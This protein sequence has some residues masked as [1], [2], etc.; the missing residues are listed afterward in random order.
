VTLFPENEA[1]LRPYLNTIVSESMKFA[2]EVRDKTHTHTYTHT[3]TRTCTY[4][5]HARSK[6][7]VMTKPCYLH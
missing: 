3:H 2:M 5:T 1:V 7:V 4:C 6:L